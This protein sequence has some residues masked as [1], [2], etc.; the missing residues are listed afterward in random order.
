MERSIARYDFSLRSISGGVI[1]LTIPPPVDSNFIT[2]TSTNLKQLYT[3]VEDCD[4]GNG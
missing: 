4:D 1:F 3:G 2:H